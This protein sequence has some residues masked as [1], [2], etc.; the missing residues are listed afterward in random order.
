MTRLAEDVEE[1]IL[2]QSLVD[3]IAQIQCTGGDLK[4]GEYDGDGERL[5]V[6]NK[7][8]MTCR[9]NMPRRE[10]GVGK[11]YKRKR[12]CIAYMESTV[13]DIFIPPLSSKP[14]SLSFVTYLL[15]S[16]TPKQVFFNP[17]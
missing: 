6:Q 11:Y 3:D 4:W 8:N 7:I 15:Y 14:V 17:I 12:A 9:R 13:V 1:E 10:N 2:E 5:C 16:K